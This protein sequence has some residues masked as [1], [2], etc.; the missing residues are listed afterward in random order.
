MKNADSLTF[1]MIFDHVRADILYNLIQT[2]QMPYLKKYIFDRAATVE[3]CFTS[4]PTNTIPGHLA[5][6]TGCYADKHHVPAMK[7]WNLSQM[8]FRDYSGLDI[9]NLLQDEY[10]EKIPMIYEFFSKSE[11]FT[12]SSFA[13]GANFTYLNKMRMIF[14]YILQMAIGYKT[15]LIHSLKT[16]LRHFKKNISGGIFVLWLPI[17]DLIGH[18]KGPTSPEF[19]QHL[20]EIDQMLFR[21]LF[22]GYKGWEGLNKLGLSESSYFIITADH[23]GFP[24][25]MKSELIKDLKLLPLQ[26][27]HKQASLQSLNKCDLLIAY[28]DGFGILYVKNPLTKNWQDKV[29]YPQLLAYPTPNN[30]V[31]LINYLLKIPTISHVFVKRKDLSSLSY[32]VFSSEGTSQIQRKIADHARLISYQVLSDKDP[33]G[34]LNNPK[35]DNLIDGAFHS[36]TEWSAVLPETNYPTLV[37]QIPRLF[38]CETMG[39]VL[40]MGKEGAS[41]TAKEKGGTHDTGVFICSR[42]PLIIA[43]PSIKH[44]TIATARTVDIVPT[45]LSLLKK[46]VDFSEFDGRVLSEMVQK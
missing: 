8:T 27:K 2:N 5:I 7:F 10:N 1:L 21:I 17:S 32:M 28:T 15:I 18:N 25:R 23:G 37:D 4:F 3:N 6:L 33:L 45:L 12:A 43:G 9:F 29:E 42:V 46:P 38:D 39:D 13:K 31:N 40:F 16:F 44:G 19:I 20:V 36:F 24:V 30:S 41:F 14:F 35:M 22:E 34:Y 11:A 26:I